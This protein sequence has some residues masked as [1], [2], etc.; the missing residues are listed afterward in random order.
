MPMEGAV[1]GRADIVVTDVDQNLPAQ[2]GMQGDGGARSALEN[3][4]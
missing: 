1:A 2:L 3:E 4:G